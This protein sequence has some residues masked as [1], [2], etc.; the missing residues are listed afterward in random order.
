VS[1]S[2]AYLRDT[3]FEDF[4]PNHA[5]KGAPVWAVY[6]GYRF[7][8]YGQRGPAMSGFSH[9]A[10]R[11]RAKMYQFI[12]GRWEL[13]ALHDPNNWPTDCERCGAP[14]IRYRAP[15]DRY[16]GHPYRLSDDTKVHTGHLEFLREKRRIIEPAESKVV[17]DSCAP[18][19]RHA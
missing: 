1:V 17:C 2:K 16:Y 3:T 19:L 7:R 9:W 5:D 11:G 12:D 6:D 10:S 13:I 8:T 4:D 15:D 18:I 14:L